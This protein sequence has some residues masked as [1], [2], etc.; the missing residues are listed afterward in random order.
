MLTAPNFK[1]VG[2]QAEIIRSFF[3]VELGSFGHT[4][5]PFCF[6]LGGCVPRQLLT[7]EYAA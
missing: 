2:L 6:L 7:G 5:A 3:G 4:Y 1:G